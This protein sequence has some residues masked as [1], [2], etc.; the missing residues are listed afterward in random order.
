MKNKSLRAQV[1][2]LIGFLGIILTTALNAGVVSIPPCAAKPGDKGFYGDVYSDFSEFY[3]ISGY[4][5]EQI[6]PV[7]FPNGVSLKKLTAFFTGPKINLHFIYVR[8]YRVK[9]ATGVAE[10]IAD[11]ISSYNVTYNRAPVSKTITSN[12][13]VVNNNVYSYVLVLYGDNGFTFNGA[14]IFY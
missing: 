2:F 11:V 4:Y 9:F 7:Y 10:I 6:F 12:T 3:D 5:M 13:R 14:Q 8:L 1:F